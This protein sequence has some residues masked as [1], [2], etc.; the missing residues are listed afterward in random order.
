MYNVCHLLFP[1]SMMIMLEFECCLVSS[2]Q[3]V[4]WLKVSLR[5]MSEERHGGRWRATRQL[6][7]NK[8]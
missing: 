5:A 6:L 8:D 4:M 7:G 1:M 2:S 3:V